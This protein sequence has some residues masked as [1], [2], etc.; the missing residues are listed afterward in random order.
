MLAA[1]V[2]IQNPGG[3]ELAPLVAALEA[4][5][6]GAQEVEREARALQVQARSAAGIIVRRPTAFLVVLSGLHSPYLDAYHTPVGQAFLLAMLA[7][8]GG[9]YLWMRRML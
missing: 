3:G 4:S 9:A 8:M 7:V 5:V 6:S 2:L 1:A